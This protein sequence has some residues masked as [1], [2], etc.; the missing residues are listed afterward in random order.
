MDF[1][2][3]AAECLTLQGMLKRLSIFANKFLTQFLQL[4]KPARISAKG[5]KELI[6]SPLD[7]LDLD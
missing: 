4:K 3:A 2:A 5:K 1:D 6:L 7:K